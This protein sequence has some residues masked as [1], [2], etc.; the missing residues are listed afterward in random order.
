[1]TA[2]HEWFLFFDEANSLVSRLQN[3]SSMAFLP[4][5][6]V[7]SHLLFSANGKTKLTYPHVQQERRQQLARNR[8]LIDS[9]VAEMSP[10]ARAATTSTSLV[11]QR[12]TKN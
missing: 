3:Y 6:F 2:G 5:V 8:N 12:T 11:R 10:T 9:V 4:F 1:M 7:T